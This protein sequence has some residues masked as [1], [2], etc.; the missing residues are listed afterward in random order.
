MSTQISD[1]D[2]D[3]VKEF[4]EKMESS[5][6]EEQKVIATEFYKKYVSV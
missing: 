3:I 6:E 4:I 5:T 1:I 2:K